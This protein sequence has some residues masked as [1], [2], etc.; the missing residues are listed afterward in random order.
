MKEQEAIRFI[1]DEW[2]DYDEIKQ[3]ARYRRNN[4]PLLPRDLDLL[5]IIFESEVHNA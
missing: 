1:L 2:G 5:E 4:G 3:A